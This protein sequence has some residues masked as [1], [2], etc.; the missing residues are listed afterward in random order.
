M[1]QHALGGFK[2]HV[3]IILLMSMGHG[4]TLLSN[5]TG[6]ELCGYMVLISEVT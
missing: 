3:L 4:Q 2:F 5:M 1:C 6:Y